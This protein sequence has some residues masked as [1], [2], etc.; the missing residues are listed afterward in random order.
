MVHIGSTTESVANFL[1][2]TK[3]DFGNATLAGIP[4]FQLHR[5]QAVMNAAARL[6][7]QSSRY[8]HI[9]PLL[10]RV[11]WLRAPERITNKLAILVYQCIRGQWLCTACCSNSRSTANSFILDL[12]TLC[13]TNTGCVRLATVLS[14]VA[15]AKVWN[16]LPAEM[17]STPSLQT[18]K[19]KL[20]THLFSVSFL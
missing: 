20:K 11:H 6:V 15:A 19:S 2:L 3:L 13:T 12:S 7:F 17:T 16:S 1:V 9:T 18:F 5:L 14:A 8:D 4:S 10:R